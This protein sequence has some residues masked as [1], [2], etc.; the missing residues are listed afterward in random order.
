MKLTKKEHAHL[1]GLVAEI[2]KVESAVGQLELQKSNA[3]EAMK[4]YMK[5]LEEVKVALTEKYGDVTI[6]VETGNITTANEKTK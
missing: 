4:A 6:E 1:Q 3:I 2:R 5:T